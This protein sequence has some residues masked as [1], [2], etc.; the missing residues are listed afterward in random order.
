[1]VNIESPTAYPNYY[2][3]NLKQDKLS[4]LTSNENPFKSIQGGHKEV[5]KYKR[6]DGLELSGTLY[7][8]VGYDMDNK[9]KITLAD[10]GISGRI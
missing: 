8:P 5:I 1:M 3:R 9:G 7:L 2:F 4:Q 6:D 10:M